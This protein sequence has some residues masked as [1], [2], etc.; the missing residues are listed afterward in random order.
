MAEN[1]LDEATS[2]SHIEIDLVVLR[3]LRTQTVV[4]FFGLASSI[5]FSLDAFHS[6]TINV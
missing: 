1:T 4:S 3:V 6:R 2:E 5:S